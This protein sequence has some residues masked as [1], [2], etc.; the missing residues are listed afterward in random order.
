[1]PAACWPSTAATRSTGSK[2]AILRACRWLFLHG[3]PG[4]GSA[5]V[6]RRFFD[7]QF[8]RIIVFDQRGCGRS[9]PLGDLQDN[10]T[11]HLVADMEKLRAHLGI[12]RW[13][14]FGGS[15]GSTLALAYGLKHPERVAGFIL[16]GIFLGSRPEIDWFL[17]GMRTI[18]PEAWRDF[19]DQ[20]PE[21][22]RSDLLGSYYR[23]LIDRNPDVHRP[24]ARA[25]SRLR[26]GLLDALSD[27]AGAVRI[28]PRR[29]CARP[30]AHRSALLRHGT[31]LPKA[32]RGPTSGASATCRAPSFRAAT[33]SFARRHRRRPGPRLAR[34]ALRDRAR[35]RPQRARARIR[36][37]LVNATES[38]RLSASD[39]ELFAPRFPWEAA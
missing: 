27:G 4:A 15:W 11:S 34:S 2:V 6:H 3:G 23:R 33:M 8:Y 21:G 9:M 19:V 14:L 35:C 32:G 38:F 17:H 30:L 39:D 22:E 24:A 36:A 7:P 25:W 37:A 29:L 13:L 12:P 10:T 31:F 20:L 28:G 16:R 18:F 26:G 1:M 5:P